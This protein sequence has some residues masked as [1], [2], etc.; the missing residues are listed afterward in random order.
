[1][2]TT[3]EWANS[4]EAARKMNTANVEKR[5]TSQPGCTNTL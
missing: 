3:T 2:D 1:M 4:T 5:V